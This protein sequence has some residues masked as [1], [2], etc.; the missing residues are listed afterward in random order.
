[1]ESGRRIIGGK[2]GRIGSWKKYR[3]L[4]GE[5]DAEGRNVGVRIGSRRND[6]RKK[7]WQQEKGMME[8]ELAT[9]R[10]IG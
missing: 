2:I 4:A 10:R 6:F 9:G 8:E 3:S 5:F 7:D 1:M